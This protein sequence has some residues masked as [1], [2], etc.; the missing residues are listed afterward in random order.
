MPR[1]RAVTTTNLTSDVPSSE[2]TD[3]LSTTQPDGNTADHIIIMS[4]DNATANS[5]A[6][7]SQSISTADSKFDTILRKLG[8]L[9]TIETQLGTQLDMLSDLVQQ[10]NN[11]E[12]RLVTLEEKQN[13]NEVRLDDISAT[14][15][16]SA[17]ATSTELENVKAENVSLRRQLDDATAARR[18]LSAQIVNVAGY[19]KVEEITISGLTH[20]TTTNLVKLVHCVA[21]ALEIDLLP[22]DVINVRR[23]GRNKVPETAVP[24]YAA[25]ASS[26]VAHESV[27][28][29]D[30]TVKLKTSDLVKQFMDAKRRASRLHT[31]KLDGT[32]LAAADAPA[33]LSALININEKLPIPLYQLLMSAKHTAKPL[34]YR[35]VWPA[36]GC[37]KVK[38][39]DS[40]PI[41]YI[42]TEDDIA[43]IKPVNAPV[44]HSNFRP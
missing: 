31:S 10:V 34:G 40:S 29:S 13:Q 22:T 7:E 9:D 43:K 1:T 11:Q 24:T 21:S 19:V 23:S 20:G 27:N 39:S 33:Q 35:Y 41:L 44:R 6:A 8:K 25:Q 14:I 42:H 12:T 36:D 15:T 32:L 37:I 38:F 2:V 16:S 17:A 5:S 30:L 18:K 4:T 26:S 3:P 28:L